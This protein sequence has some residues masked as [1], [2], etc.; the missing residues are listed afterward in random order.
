MTEA[1][2]VPHAALASAEH[3][4][5]A[6]FPAWQIAPVRGGMWGGYWQ[7]GDGRRRR[8]IVA[9]SAPQLLDVLRARAAE[10]TAPA[11]TAP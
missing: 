8:Y 4:L 1:F 2:P 7:S 9:P 3:A 11:A 5:A 10:N 6:E